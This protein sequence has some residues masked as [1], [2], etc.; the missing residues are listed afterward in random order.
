MRNPHENP[1]DT[2]MRDATV[3]V[4]LRRELAAAFRGPG[5]RA[6]RRRAAAVV[7]AHG[8]YGRCPG[9]QAD[10]AG[11]AAT[12]ARRTPSTRLPEQRTSQP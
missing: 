7:K 3:P 10:T 12:V 11:R 6:V 4:P 2:S 9:P 1:P 5:R 8:S